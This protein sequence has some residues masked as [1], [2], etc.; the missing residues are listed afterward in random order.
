MKR[1]SE[2]SAATALKRMREGGGTETSPPAPAA[3]RDATISSDNSQQEHPSEQ[4]GLD[5]SPKN[6]RQNQWSARF[7]QLVEFKEKYGHSQVP[8]GWSVSLLAR[9]R[10]EHTKAVIAVGFCV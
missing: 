9:C 1:S 6:P 10:V 2:A 4:L 8:I 3:P 5:S 7:Q